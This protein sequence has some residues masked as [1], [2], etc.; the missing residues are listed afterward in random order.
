MGEGATRDFTWAQVMDESRR[1]AANLQSL[2]LPPGARIAIQSKN[3]AHWLMSDF[4]I[5]L[6]GFVS[7]PLYLTLTAGTTRQIL[8]HSGSSLLFVGKLDGYESMKAGIPAGL[9]CISHPLSPDD[10]K[11]SYRAWDDII[12]KTAPL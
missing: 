12:A 7:A 10:A 11:K 1:M 4:A 2:G 8:E 6:A 9:P 3:T 5:W